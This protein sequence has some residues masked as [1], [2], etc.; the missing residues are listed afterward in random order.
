M[1]DEQLIDN[2]IKQLGCS[3]P[4]HACE[5]RDILRKAF[6]EVREEAMLDAAEVALMAASFGY[7]DPTTSPQWYWTR[8]EEWKEFL[9][10]DHFGDCTNQPNSCMRCVTEDNIKLAKALVE[11]KP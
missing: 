9:G 2:L 7:G 5:Q 1:I 8:W 6:E 3:S 10:K 11:A 4:P